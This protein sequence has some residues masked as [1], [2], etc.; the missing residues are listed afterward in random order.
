MAFSKTVIVMSD[1]PAPEQELELFVM[2]MSNDSCQRE[3]VSLGVIRHHSLPELYLKMKINKTQIVKGAHRDMKFG[4]AL[5]PNFDV[6]VLGDDI[7]RHLNCPTRS[8]KPGL[9]A[10]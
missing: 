3:D 4:Q 9:I 2:D 7:P 8:R 6:H 5:L 1:V 10:R